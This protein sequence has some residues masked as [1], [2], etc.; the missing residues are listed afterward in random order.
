MF[1]LAIVVAFFVGFLCGAIFFRRHG[2]RIEADINAVSAVAQ[3]VKD[4]TKAL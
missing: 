2:D 3:N 4:T 1:A